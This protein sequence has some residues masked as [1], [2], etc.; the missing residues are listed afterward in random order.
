MRWQRWA[1]IGF[2]AVVIKVMLWAIA[3]GLTRRIHIANG[4]P[5]SLTRKKKE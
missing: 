2:S 5:L 1:M 3:L 4:A